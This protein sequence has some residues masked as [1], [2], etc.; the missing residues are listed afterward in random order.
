MSR[1]APKKSDMG[2]AW[3]KPRRNI[4]QMISPEYHLIVS[5]GTDTEPMYFR[6]IK[7]IVESKYRGRIFLDISGKG[8]N[9]VNLF[10]H[11]VNDVVNSNI[12][13]KHVWLIYDKD[14]FPSEHFDKTAELCESAGSEET[15]YHAIWSN[16]C[17]ELWF[18]LHF[19]FLQADLHRN[20]YWPKLTE[21]LNAIGKGDYTKNRSDMFEIL[22]PYMDDA[23]R[24][25]IKLQEINQG[26]TP[27]RSAPGTKMHLLIDSLKPYL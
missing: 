25:A 22:R 1:N 3:I 20:E 27:T 23:V 2:K 19:M 13:Y 16:Q 8:E 14:D 11:A 18:L 12:V 10:N 4:G 21:Q 17:I 15:A 7:D 9:T 5:E 26:R 6:S 24:N